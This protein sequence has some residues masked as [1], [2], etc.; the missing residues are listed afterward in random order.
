MKR[1]SVSLLGILLLSGVSC[2]KKKDPWSE[3]FTGCRISQVTKIGPYNTGYVPDKRVIYAY[4]YN[5]N[6]TVKAITSIDVN[7]QDYLYYSTLYSANTVVLYTSYQA[8][9]TP[10]VKDSFTLDDAGRI[11][12]FFHNNL[13]NPN[14]QIWDKYQ[15]D[16]SGEMTLHTS[17]H[18]AG[19]T[20]DTFQWMNG[21][22]VRFA[23]DDS[24]GI[25]P[26]ATK[27][28][29]ADTLFNTGN[30]PVQPEDF[31]SYGR[32]IYATR[33]LLRWA[34]F[35]PAND[36]TR[37]SY[38]LDNGGRILSWTETQQRGGV[39]TYEFVYRCE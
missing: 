37:Y 20:T 18:F 26:K 22:V 39:T 30:T 35:K 3:K 16:S 8:G 13:P 25:D 33:H 10:F 24:W 9:G 12:L 2:T 31:I 14:Y 11:T 28:W 36:T 32:G 23:N 34:V 6:G 38:T 17:H 4:T 5:S 29:Y 19:E 7:R 27:F 21:D 15:Y 1:V